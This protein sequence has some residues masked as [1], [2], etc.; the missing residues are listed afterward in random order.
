M[1]ER[2]AST[3][4]AASLAD[5][6]GISERVVLRILT[7]V[8]EGELR[9]RVGER[10]FR[11]GERTD[12]FPVCARVEIRDRRAFR[13]ML[14]GGSVGAGEAFMD[15]WWR[16]DD[17]VA[18]LR[19]FARNQRAMHSLRT[20]WTVL[21]TAAN[22]VRHWLRSNTIAGSRQNIADHYDLGNE[23]FEQFLDPTMT[24]SAGVFDE[25]GAT[26]EHASIAKYRRLCEKLAIS[27]EHHVLEIGTGW[28]GFAEFA[29]REY[30]CRVT[31]TTISAQQHAYARKRIERA[32]LSGRVTLLDRDY[33]ELSGSYDRIVSIEMIE[34]VGHDHH[35]E[36]FAA[37]HK[38]LNPEGMIG[39]QCI[40][41]GEDRYR[42]SVGEVDFI[43]RYIF[44]G[45]C[46][47]SVGRIADCVARKSDLAV[48]HLEDITRDYATTLRLWRERFLENIEG[49]RAHGYTERFLRMWEFY[50]AYCEA[51]FRERYIRDLQVVLTGPKC[52]SAPP[53]S[54]IR[55][56]DASH[57]ASVER[58]SER[59]VR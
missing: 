50:L 58:A 39:L 5:A 54:P 18:L 4:I 33:R 38:H 26:M 7:R 2:T 43:K 16:A 40:T 34:A 59:E 12:A 55:V 24:Y 36:F 37:L 15:G 32:G 31:T 6:A 17:L 29:A 52:T 35:D 57:S 8:T 28:G 14:F 45:S 30:G 20:R 47:L 46:L 51:G 56:E 19:I 3:P 13:K 48:A 27:R 11:F 53:R 44:P 21:A 1:I 49:I 41:I 9:L 25:P 23:F 10:L 42:A 22:R